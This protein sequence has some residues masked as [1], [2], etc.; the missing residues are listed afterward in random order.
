MTSPAAAWRAEDYT[1]VNANQ[2]RTALVALSMAEGALEEGGWFAD[3]GCGTGEVARAMA[4]RDF[5]VF[6]SDAS[7]SM[8]TATAKLCA[9][10][11]VESSEV[12]AEKLE[13]S[14]GA[15][16]IVHCSW[17]LHWLEEID[18]PLRRMARALRPGGHLVLQWTG[19]QARSEGAGQFGILRA[20]AASPQWRKALAEA[21]LAVRSYPADDVVA[22]LQDEGL[23]IVVLERDLV[24]PTS[25]DQEEGV[26]EA[27]LAEVRRRMRLSGFGAQAEAL[28][29]RA[30]DFFGDVLAAMVEAG[31]T[32]PRD[33]RVLAK[34]P[35]GTA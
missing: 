24:H 15:F 16:T 18:Q 10:L 28:G 3:V 31:E 27:D 1:Q 20:C 6:A 23:E 12:P 8:V 11:A 19:A 17:V 9:G 30:D 4:E 32:D 29:D 2:V 33:A 22:I 7:P 21:P 26:T 14:E 25:V 13:L 34:R 5:E 35:G